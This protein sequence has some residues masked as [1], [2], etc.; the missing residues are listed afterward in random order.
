MTDL[1][2]MPPLRYAGPP[3]GPACVGVTEMAELAWLPVDEASWSVNGLTR[4]GKSVFLAGLIRQ[5]APREHT[6]LV[7]ADPKMV[8]FVGWHDRASSLAL[9]VEAVRDQCRWV[10]GEVKRRYTAICDVHTWRVQR[11]VQVGPTMPHIV[12]IVDECAEVFKGKEGAALVDAFHSVMTLCLATRITPILAT[13]RPDTDSIPNKIRSAT[14]IRVGF[15]TADEL[16]SRM[17]FGIGGV[18]AHEIPQAHKGVGYFI[19]DGDRRA[20]KFRSANVTDAEIEHAAALTAGL[21]VPLD[22]VGLRWELLSPI[23]ANI[24]EEVSA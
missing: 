13:Q 17:A 21:R 2:A 12:W 9:G 10:I 7:L 24:K 5:L 15:A 19:A 11:K 22:D 20:M 14:T 18:A 1:P 6:A 3:L 8:E 23:L 4:S 16:H